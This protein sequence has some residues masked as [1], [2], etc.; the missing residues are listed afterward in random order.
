MESASTI[1]DR[2]EGKGGNDEIEREV[3]ERYNHIG[4]RNRP[5]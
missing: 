2:I 4:V 3:I 1:T 5:E